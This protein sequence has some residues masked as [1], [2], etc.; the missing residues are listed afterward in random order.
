MTANSPL[1]SSP[2]RSAPYQGFDVIDRNGKSDSFGAAGNRRVD[3]DYLAVEVYQRASAVSRID[4]RIGLNQVDQIFTALG[5]PGRNI[6]SDAADDAG[7]NGILVFGQSVADSDDF[8]FL[9]SRPYPGQVPER[10]Y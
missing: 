3:S 1:A 7:G 2:T 8:L 5:R 6:A 4:G 10:A 9:C